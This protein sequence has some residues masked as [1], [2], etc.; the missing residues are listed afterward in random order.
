MHAGMG[1]PEGWLFLGAVAELF[2]WGIFLGVKGLLAPHPG[3]DPGPRPR[4]PAAYDWRLIEAKRDLY[5]V[6]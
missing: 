3:A 6:A 4:T 5:R 1:S 2:A